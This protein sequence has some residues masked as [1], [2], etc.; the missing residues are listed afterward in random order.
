M[1]TLLLKFKSIAVMKR[2]NAVFLQAGIKV[3]ALI[4]KNRLIVD[5]NVGKCLHIISL[6]STAFTIYLPVRL[7]LFHFSFICSSSAQFEDT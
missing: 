3:F 6:V 2:K 7:L 1:E 5:S 4:L